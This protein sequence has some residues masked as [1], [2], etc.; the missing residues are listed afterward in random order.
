[1]L[2]KWFACATI[3]IL[4]Y[5]L[6]LEINTTYGEQRISL[7]RPVETQYPISQ[8]FGPSSDQ[9]LQEAYKKWG[10][11]GHF[12]IDYA[13]PVGTD[14]FACDDGEVFEANNSNPKHPNG[15]YVRI[16]HK[17]GSSVYLHLSSVAVLNGKRVAKNTVI[18]SSGKTGY[19]TGAHLHFG[20]RISGIP[21]PGYKD[22]IDPKK[23]ASFESPVTQLSTSQT[24]E[25]KKLPEVAKFPEYSQETL[26]L[27][28]RIKVYKNKLQSVSSQLLRNI[29]NPPSIE[30]K[31]T[32][33][34]EVNAWADG[35]I[36]MRLMDFLYVNPTGNPDDQLA[37]VLAH[38][39]I[40]EKLKTESVNKMLADGLESSKATYNDIINGV[41]Y[42]VSAV[43]GPTPLS[44]AS[45]V[46][47]E[48]SKEIV[49][50]ITKKTLKTFRKK[51]ENT[52]HF[53][54][55]LYVNKAGFD[56]GEGLKIFNNPTA[57][58]RQHPINRQFWKDYAK[59][60]QAKLDSERQLATNTLTEQ[61]KPPEVA[62]LPEFSQETIL[63]DK[64]TIKDGLIKQKGSYKIYIL[65]DG[66]KYFIPDR[67]TL[68]SLNFGG[69]SV[70]ALTSDVFNSI[71]EGN[72]KE[73]FALKKKG[74][75]SGREEEATAI[76]KP[77][78]THGKFRNKLK[79]GKLENR[80]VEV[81]E[82]EKPVVMQDIA[83]G[84]EDI[85]V[86]ILARTDREV[87]KVFDAFQQWRIDFMKRLAANKILFF[88][89][90]ALNLER[91]GAWKVMDCILYA[92]ENNDIVELEKSIEEYKDLIKSEVRI[93][94]NQKA[95]YIPTSPL[96]SEFH[97]QEQ[98][99][100]S[101]TMRL[102]L[103]TLNK[104]HLLPPSARITSKK[105][106][107]PSAKSDFVI[108]EA[109]KRDRGYS[110]QNVPSY[111][112]G[113]SEINN[114]NNMNELQLLELEILE[115]LTK[116][117]WGKGG[118]EFSKAL[119]RNAMDAFANSTGYIMS[120]VLKSNPSL[121][122]KL[123]QYQ[124]MQERLLKVTKQQLMHPRY[125]T[126]YNHN[127]PYQTTPMITNQN[128][129][130]RDGYTVGLDRI[131][132]YSTSD[133]NI[134]SVNIPINEVVLQ[135]GLGEGKDIWITSVY[136]HA[137]GGGG[138]GGGRD[139]EWLEMGGWGDSYHILIEFDLTNSPPTTLSARVELFVG[140][141][142]G[143]ET[144][145]VYVDRITEFWDW[146][147]QGTG[148][149]HERLWWA[150]RPSATQLTPSPL[151]APTV[152][153]WYIIDVT[154]LYNAWKD[155]TYPNYGIQLRPVSNDNRWNKYFSSDYMGDP[156]LRPKLV[157]QVP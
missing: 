72:F 38:I 70:R 110:S 82:Q 7:V 43:L 99:Y 33:S 46:L 8:P 39:M 109:Y 119:D 90:N 24:T 97:W 81:K 116:A 78:T 1:M 135:P 6:S 84:I 88:P 103:A 122:R 36:T 149:D 52:S 35:R 156:S 150:D 153:Q 42:A 113:F 152:G 108:P 85:G 21:N 133:L 68:K 151:P 22:Y 45:T 123:K 5:S 83:T 67:A 40:H 17:W 19:V 114:L 65:L 140:E 94:K 58:S 139:N 91:K 102:S 107:S 41:S 98:N 145:G 51:Q 129:G 106:E 117:D 60:V 80:V 138:P 2:K 71:P 63:P 93:I 105:R 121:E 136:S 120:G 13:C 86:D 101:K 112:Q 62:K 148:L 154:N 61:K 64:V 134:Q 157:I 155:G 141:I 146:R 26:Q 118:E 34:E 14:I 50:W 73:F 32:A 125:G 77:E 127:I 29:P 100:K 126:G 147:I 18:G 111:T 53:F 11:N 27:R 115:E 75:W 15:L 47:G 48:G 130:K 128:K 23:Y 76:E 20:L 124:R 9:T 55:V 10:Y 144:T 4:C 49:N 87:E 69:Q 95:G 56:A 12:G 59:E 25:Q 96:M 131:K 104:Q 16:K 132:N 44:L 57:F 143:D 74:R 37:M 142:K 79:Q 54:S 28:E 30:F 31:L 66:K 92:W 89:E 3:S 137:P